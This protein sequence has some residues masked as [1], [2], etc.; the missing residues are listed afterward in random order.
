MY[1]S[2]LKVWNFRKFGTDSD[3]LS[4]VPDLSVDFKDGLT[5]IVGEN[6]SGKSTIVDAINYIILPSS[7]EYLRIDRDD[8]YKDQKKLRL[9]C[10]LTGFTSLQAKDFLEYLTIEDNSDVGL[11]PSFED[12]IERDC[13]LDLNV[14]K[15]Q[16]TLFLQAEI[17]NDKLS[18]Y[19]VKV[20]DTD[21]G[22]LLK[23]ETRDLLKSMYL[24]PLR[25]AKNELKA[26]PYSRLS[27]ILLKHESFK[28][29]DGEKHPLVKIFESANLN[30]KDFFSDDE[31]EFTEEDK[32]S[33]ESEFSLILDS[34]YSNPCEDNKIKLEVLISKVARVSQKNETRGRLVNDELSNHIGS[35]FSK[36]DKK[37]FKFDTTDPVIDQVLQK[38]SLELTDKKSGLG[39]LNLLFIAVEL[40]LLNK[41]NQP[42]LHLGIIEEIEAHLH[43]QS[44]LRVLNYLQDLSDKENIQLIVTTHSSQIASQINLENLIISQGNKVFSM[45]SDFTKLD[46]SD[47]AFLER[48]LDATKANLFFAEGVIM[49]EGDAENL[50]IPALASLI[51]KDLISYGISIVNVGHTGLFRYSR[52][53]QRKDD[54]TDVIDIPVACVRDNDISYV[55]DDSNLLL[56]DQSLLQSSITQKEKDD[57]GQGVKNFVSPNWTFEFDIALDPFLRKDFYRAVL[58]AEKTKNAKS[59]IF[60]TDEKKHEANTL[61]D[62]DFTNWNQQDLINEKIALNIYKKCKDNKSITAQFYSEL[63]ISKKDDIA[64]KEYL[65]GDECK[66]KY[67]ISAIKYVTNIEE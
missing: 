44:Q 60:I 57:A 62:S 67:I 6:D 58:Y 17:K 19:D 1:L 34:F 35:L 3:D 63:L 7:H 24:K 28:I 2:N 51:D 50:V 55:D 49:V 54:S 52:I 4:R 64:Y 25:D 46:K 48:F 23:A 40:L 21:G 27:Q 30:I 32:N 8:F 13:W 5:L 47:Y 61:V 12:N 59:T 56:P 37:R 9:E 20:K 38:I 15:L 22:S 41:N 66:L 31:F 16:L 10:T 29:K 26:R 53:F 42:G 18:F 39:S 33:L 14:K 65:N 36:R 11:P 43:T 45:R